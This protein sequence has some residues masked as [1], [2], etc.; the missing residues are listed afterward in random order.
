MIG[1][2]ILVGILGVAVW[3]SFVT[4]W[5]YN[6]TLSLKN[7]D[8]GDFDADG[9]SPTSTRSGWRRGPR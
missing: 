7:Y 1:G 9:W 3:A 2:L 4:Y 8:F 5:P 6:L